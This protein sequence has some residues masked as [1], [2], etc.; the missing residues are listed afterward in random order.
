[1]T[2]C[3]LQELVSIL[4]A[5]V[6]KTFDRGSKVLDFHHPH[7]LKEGLEGFSL[8]LPDQPENLEQILVDCRD[9]LKYGVKT[10]RHNHH[11]NHNYN[12]Y[13]YGAVQESQANHRLFLAIIHIGVQIFGHPWFK[14]QFYN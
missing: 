10:G 4:L 13:F 3:F 14:C 12:I 6:T 8:D 2:R 11:N 9:T 7:Q 1:M 5:Y